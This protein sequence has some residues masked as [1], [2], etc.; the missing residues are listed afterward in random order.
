MDETA[1]LSDWYKKNKDRGV[2]IVMLAYERTT[3]F[4]KS[5]KAAEGFAKK[6]DVTY[7]V[8]ITGVTPADPQKTEKTLPS[9]QASKASRQLFTSTGAAR[10]WKCIPGSTV[11][12]RASIMKSIRRN[13]MN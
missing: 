10:W 11:R 1:Y 4:E 13:S 12:V 5:K 9:S 3:D 6:F 8:L 7:P 2:E